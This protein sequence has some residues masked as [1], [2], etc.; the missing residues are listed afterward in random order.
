M[1]VETLRPNAPGDVT[2]CFPWPTELENWE[3]VDDVV[4]DEST[5]LIYLS[6]GDKY[7]LYNIPA[8]GASGV[9]N[10]VK[11]HI[12]CKETGTGGTARTKIKIGG[13]EYA[14]SEINLNSN[15][16]TYST[17]YDENPKTGMPWTWDEINDELQIGVL[18]HY[19][20]AGVNCTQAYVEIDYT[21]PPAFR[22]SRGFIIG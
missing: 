21:P 1:T 20:T 6:S 16:T 2:Q 15:W 22:G 3:A 13:T 19:G 8:S 4:P 18:L 10:F 12:R 17:Q 9:I 7:D 5:T 14:G 11:V